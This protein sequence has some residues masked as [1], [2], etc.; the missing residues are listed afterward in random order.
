MFVVKNFLMRKKNS[1]QTGPIETGKLFET[2]QI[3][4]MIEERDE[5]EKQR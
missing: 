2:A 5:T 4:E 3:N 1:K